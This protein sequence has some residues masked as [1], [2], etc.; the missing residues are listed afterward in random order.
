MFNDNV[1]TTDVTWLRKKQE[2][3]C[4]FWIIKYMLQTDCSLFADTIPPTPHPSIV[5]VNLR[6]I[7]ILSQN[8]C[9]S[10]HNFTLEDAKCMW[11]IFG[12]T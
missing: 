7:H 12:F 2:D 8:V 4:K 3:V 1:S 5:F 6:N 11:L 10:D 9:K